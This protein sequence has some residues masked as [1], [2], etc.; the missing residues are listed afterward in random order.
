MRLDE[1]QTLSIDDAACWVIGQALDKPDANYLWLTK[2]YAVAKDTLKLMSR[3][4][5]KCGAR[6]TNGYKY[7]AAQL[8][9]TLPNQSRVFVRDARPEHLCG[10]ALDGVLL[11]QWLDYDVAVASSTCL[12]RTKGWM[13]KVKD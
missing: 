11:S 1:V 8:F 10:M 13:Y 7:S 12:T 6:N 3:I 2:T 4:L 5:L 9:Y